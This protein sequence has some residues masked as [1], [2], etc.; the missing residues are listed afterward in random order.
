M[1]KS[2][3][4]DDF[5]DVEAN[6]I[7]NEPSENDFASALLSMNRTML[8]MGESLKR[9]HDQQDQLLNSAESAKKAKLGNWTMSNSLNQTQATALNQ[10]NE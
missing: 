4:E 6:E 2:Q 10:R 7:L 5:D 1:A 8:T 3:A 9:L